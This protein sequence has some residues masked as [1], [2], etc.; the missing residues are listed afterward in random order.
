MVLG[1]QQSTPLKNMVLK[2]WSRQKCHKAVC[3]D[4]KVMDKPIS[5]RCYLYIIKNGVRLEVQGGLRR[6]YTA[7]LLLSSSPP[8]HL[9][10]IWVQDSQNISVR[11]FVSFIH[12]SVS[13]EKKRKHCPYSVSTLSNVKPCVRKYVKLFGITLKKTTS[14]TILVLYF[15]TNYYFLKFV[16]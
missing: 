12:C 8:L 10:E 15:N 16:S 11:L 1:G 2:T 14:E 3:N 9:N 4:G 13:R 6:A 7:P 5:F